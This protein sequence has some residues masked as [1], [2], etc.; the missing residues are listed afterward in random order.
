MYLPESTYWVARQTKICSWASIGFAFLLLLFGVGAMSQDRKGWLYMPEV[1]I[2]GIVFTV[3]SLL[4]LIL[5][6]IALG[7]LGNKGPDRERHAAWVAVAA[8]TL[9]GLH[10]WRMEVR[11]ACPGEVQWQAVQVGPT[12][13]GAGRTRQPHDHAWRI[14]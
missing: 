3:V 5:F 4:Q 14:R 6:F 1:T 13:L 9:G 12:L 2:I 8:T 7:I 11:M 10:R